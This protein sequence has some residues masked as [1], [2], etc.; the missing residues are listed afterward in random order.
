VFEIEFQYYL[1]NQSQLNEKYGGRFLAIKGDSVLG[2][3][4]TEQEAYLQTKKIYEVGSF[5]IQK[6][7]IGNSDESGHV[8]IF[9]SRVAFA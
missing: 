8:Q 9:H 5:L 3:Y 6:C 4:A 7:T 2:D 1:T